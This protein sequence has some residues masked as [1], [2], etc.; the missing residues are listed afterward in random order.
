MLLGVALLLLA[1]AASAQAPAG[2]QMVQGARRNFG[3]QLTGNKQVGPPLRASC[4]RLFCW[5]PP[6]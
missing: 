3:A 2:E 5:Q 1:V 6:E 4:A